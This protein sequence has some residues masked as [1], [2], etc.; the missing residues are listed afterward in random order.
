MYSFWLF[1]YVSGEDPAGLTLSSTQFVLAMSETQVANLL[2]QKYASEYEV[3]ADEF[4]KR[5][6]ESIA[7]IGSEAAGVL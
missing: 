5:S 4:V 6:I 3:D 1:D 7:E 2:W